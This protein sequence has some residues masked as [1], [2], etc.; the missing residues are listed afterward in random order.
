MKILSILKFCFEGN[1]YLEEETSFAG[2][3]IIENNNL[4]YF[5]ALVKKI[6]INSGV[7]SVTYYDGVMIKNSKWEE[8]KLFQLNWL[9]PVSPTWDETS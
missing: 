3:C 5:L 2:H 7:T 1:E 9:E 6:E 4:F 8:Q